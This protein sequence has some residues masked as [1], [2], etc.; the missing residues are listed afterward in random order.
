MK[1]A[2]ISPLP[3][4]SLDLDST[5]ATAAVLEPDPDLKLHY[6]HSLNCHMNR[7]LLIYK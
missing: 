2:E 3:D 4:S 6:Y 1:V 5:Q 7:R